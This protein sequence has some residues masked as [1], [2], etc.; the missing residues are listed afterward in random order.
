MTVGSFKEPVVLLGPENTLRTLNQWASITIIPFALSSIITIF[1]HIFHFAE[2]S[3]T[4]RVTAYFSLLAMLAGFL[5]L[6][7]LISILART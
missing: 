3:R 2:N 7:F 1:A 6:I 5:Y 4:H